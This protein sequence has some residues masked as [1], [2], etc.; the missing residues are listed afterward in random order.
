MSASSSWPER[1]ASEILSALAEIDAD[2][3]L[4]LLDRVVGL[5]SVEELK[6][7]KGNTGRHLVWA[8]EKI[9]F[10]EATF[11][12]AA[13]LLPS[14]AAAENETWGNNATGRF[15]RLFPVFLSDTVAG[16]EARLRLIDELVAQNDPSRMPIVVDALLRG[17]DINSSHRMVGAE[18]HGSRPALEPWDPKLWKDAW[19]YVVACLDRLAILSLRNDA[20]GARARARMPHTFRPMASAGLIDPIEACVH[21]RARPP[22][23]SNG[24]VSRF[25]I[26]LICREAPCRIRRRPFIW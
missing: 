7:V 13:L 22:S 10:L 6:E 1:S 21:R 15:K 20:I 23:W 11:E 4:T 25:R 16:P 14:L 9:A 17:A 8:L 24:V 2:A 26:A 5:L 19:D 18:T 12:R 3:V